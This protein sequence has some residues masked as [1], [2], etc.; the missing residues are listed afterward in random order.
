MKINHVFLPIKDVVDSFVDNGF[1]GVFAMNG[2]LNIRP[3]Y[4]REFVYTE[5]QQQAVIDSILKGYPL[6][7]LYWTQ[8]SDGKMDVIDGQQRIMSICRFVTGT[9]YCLDS[10]GNEQYFEGLTDAEK[11]RIRNYKLSVHLCLGTDEERLEWFRV[12]NTVGEKLNQQ[13]LRNAVYTSPWLTH[14]KRSFSAI[15]CPVSTIAEPYVKGSPIRQ[16]LLET[17]LK[18]KSEGDINVYMAK[19]S[20]EQGDATELLTYAM[21]LTRWIERSFPTYRKEMKGVDW[22]FLY[23]NFKD[24]EINPVEL[25]EQIKSLMADED[26]SKK[27]GVYAY[28]LTGE[29]KFLSIRAFTDKMKREAYER[30]EG[31]CALSG[32]KMDIKLMEADHIVAWSQG[33]KTTLDNCQMISKKLNRIKGAL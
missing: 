3:P 23:N 19:C 1:E 10:N 29:E 32:E 24:V 18:W 16:E 26:V 9:T 21:N 17:F 6:G 7:V 25:E 31:I 11:D 14:A 22:G 13:E 20:S 15:N 30:Q 33:G 4:Q 12:I 8:H 28:V 27:S 2:L 5:K